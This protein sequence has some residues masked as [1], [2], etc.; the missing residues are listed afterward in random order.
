MRLCSSTYLWVHSSYNDGADKLWSESLKEIIIIKFQLALY[1]NIAGHYSERIGS[2][3]H[4]YS[5]KL[6]LQVEPEMTLRIPVALTEALHSDLST[7]NG[8]NCLQ[9]WL[10]EISQCLL[11]EYL[12]V[13]STHKHIQVHRHAHK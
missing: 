10:Q 11:S 6:G 9:L 13:C 1:R 5:R 3:K 4:L 8:H 7:H 2:A 12:S